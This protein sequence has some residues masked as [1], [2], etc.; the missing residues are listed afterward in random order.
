M[1]QQNYLC[2]GKVNY[3]T[4]P[5]AT[6]TKTVAGTGSMHFCIPFQICLYIEREIERYMEH[7]TSQFVAHSLVFQRCFDVFKIVWRRECFCLDKFT[8]DRSRVG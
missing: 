6:T 7:T 2:L 8:N 1:S 3:I 5:E 4:T